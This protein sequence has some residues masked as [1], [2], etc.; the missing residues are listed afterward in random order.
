[1]REETIDVDGPEALGNSDV[2]LRREVLVA[3]EHDAVFTK[4]AADLAEGLV[5]QRLREIDA[6]DLRTDIGR[7]RHHP[8]V[9]VRHCHSPTNIRAYG[10]CIRK[11]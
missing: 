3:K 6:A 9:L 1:M 11:I 8:D 10:H 4:G 7:R 5:L 2:L